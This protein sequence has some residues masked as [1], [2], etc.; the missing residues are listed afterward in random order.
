[1]MKCLF[2]EQLSTK[3]LFRRKQFLVSRLGENGR[4]S[5]GQTGGHL[6]LVGLQREREAVGG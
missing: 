1:M 4:S 2:V 3:H 5:S 6:W